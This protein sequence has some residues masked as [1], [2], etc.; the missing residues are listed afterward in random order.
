MASFK[1][2]KL[3][4][5][6]KRFGLKQVSESLTLTQWLA[7]EADITDFEREFLLHFKKNLQKNMFHWNEIELSMHFIG[8]LLSLVDFTTDN[9][10]LFEE[11]ELRG[12]VDG[13]EMYGFPDGMIA[14]GFREPE[15]PFFCL[16]EYKKE[17]DPNGDPVAQCLGAMLTAQT[18]NENEFPMFGIYIIGQN[19]SFMVLEGRKYAI[20]SSYSASTD[21]IFDIFRRLK[22]LKNVLTI[23]SN[24]LKENK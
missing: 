22:Y 20:S 4:A 7:G 19:W 3:S 23:Q 10:N 16:K 13:E 18:L 21:E 6:D 5:L 9:F 15:M 14:S 11:R 2:W 17:T 24:K 12:K 1:E 8:P